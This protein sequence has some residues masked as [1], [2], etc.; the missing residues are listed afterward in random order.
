ME[1]PEKACRT[2][3]LANKTVAAYVNTSNW[4]I[5]R[6]A[7]KYWTNEECGEVIRN[8]NAGDGNY[9]RITLIN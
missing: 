4:K 1:R 7:K 6:N 3:F 9:L 2:I 8:M 5:L